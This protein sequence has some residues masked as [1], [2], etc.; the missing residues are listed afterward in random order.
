MAEWISDLAQ[1][2]AIV[3]GA[4]ETY[5]RYSHGPAA[6]TGATS[7]DYESGLELPGLSVVPLRPPDWWTRPVP[8]WIARQI[9]KYAQLAAGDRDR[10]AWILTGPVVGRGPDHEPLVAPAQPVAMLSDDLVEEA[11]RRYHERFE[12][13]RD[14]AGH[15]TR[16]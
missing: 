15:A 7:R 16:A 10:Y 13:G 12:V 4:A 3:N 2:T 11:H 9:C 1:L 5:L 6:D 14:S 8:D